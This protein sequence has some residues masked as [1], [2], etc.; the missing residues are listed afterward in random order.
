MN[1]AI[2]CDYELCQ[3]PTVLASEELIALCDKVPFNWVASRNKILGLIEFVLE[4]G[5]SAGVQ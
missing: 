4:T 2:N 5:A 3:E 1:I